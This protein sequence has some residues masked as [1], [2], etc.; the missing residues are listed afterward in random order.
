MAQQLALQNKILINSSKNTT[1]RIL[2]AAFGN[3]YSQIANDGLNSSIDSWTIIY[4]PL[5]ST[6]LTT[7]QTFITSVGVVTFFDWIPFGEVVN[8][9]WRIVKDSI[10]ERFINK[11][12]RQISF[13]IEQVFD[14]G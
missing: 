7:L 5:D 3:G 14:L 2:K 9:K 10:R 12:T 4:A 1:N 13:K 8:K 6:D 11:S